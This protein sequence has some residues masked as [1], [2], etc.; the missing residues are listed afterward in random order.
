MRPHVWKEGEIFVFG[1]NL[2]GVHGAGAA[3][4]ARQHCGAE[5]GVGEG[6]TGQSYALPTCKHP[7]IPLTYYEVSWAID[8][9]I[10]FAQRRL[11]LQ[12]FVSRVGCGLAGF[13]D[14][15]IAYQFSNL[16]SNLRLPPEWDG[17]DF[18]SYRKTM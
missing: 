7:G 4:F 5:L 1:S 2:D 9:F 8:R 12:F 6:L 18:E 10:N 3:L 13:T 11:D 15:E 17:L 14:T 16:P